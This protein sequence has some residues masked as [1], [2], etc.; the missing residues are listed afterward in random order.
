M[1][2]TIQAQLECWTVFL[3][4]WEMALHET[5]EVIMMMEANLDF[6]N[7]SES[8]LP[9]TDQTVRLKP[10]IEQLFSRIFTLGVSQL[11]TT[12][13]RAWHGQRES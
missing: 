12:A 9:A 13:T 6:L 11:V 10:F 8:N 7:W 5:K 1:S 2:G 4:K 3:E